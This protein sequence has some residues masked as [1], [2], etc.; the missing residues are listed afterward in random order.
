MHLV[1]WLVA[2][3]RGERLVQ[4]VDG[5]E[6]LLRPAGVDLQQQMQLIDRLQIGEF[7]ENGLVVDCVHAGDLKRLVPHDAGM[8]RR[9]FRR[10]VAGA[11]AIVPDLG[12]V[13]REASATVADRPA[14]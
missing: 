9:K 8:A 12:E 6:D 14:G 10:A 3:K 1:V 4:L 11:V 13:V 7:D 2:G 5:D